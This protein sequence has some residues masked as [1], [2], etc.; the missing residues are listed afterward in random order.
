MT[1]SY[2]KSYHGLPERRRAE[3]MVLGAA[4][5]AYGSVRAV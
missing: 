3:Q 1:C 4:E 2:M 5:W